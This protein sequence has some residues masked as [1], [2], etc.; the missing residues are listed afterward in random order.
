[1]LRGWTAAVLI[2]VLLGLVE[3]PGTGGAVAQTSEISGDPNNPR[4]HF[5]VRHPARLTAEEA[6]EVYRGLV[7]ELSA[8]YASSEDPVALDY[9]GWRRANSAPYLSSTHGNVYLNNYVNDTAGAYLRYEAAG[10]LPVG[11]VVVK[12]SFIVE[13]DGAMRPGALFVMEKMPEGFNYVS[14]DWRYAMIMPDGVLFGETHGEDSERV[15]YCIG[16]H[17]AVERQDHLYFVPRDFRVG[18]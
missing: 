16:C 11:S 13:R 5:R 8:G 2:A 10:T 1:M 18:P 17:L 6:E 7:E 9:R 15:D 4:R 3:G 14:G 12:D